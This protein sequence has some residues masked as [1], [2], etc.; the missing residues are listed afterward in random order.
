MRASRRRAFAAGVL[1]LT[2]LPYSFFMLATGRTRALEATHRDFDAA[3][4]WL[5]G[6]RARPGVVLSRHPGEVYLRTGR[7][8]L[9]VST[10][11]RP[12]LENADP[13]SVAQTINDYGVAYLLIDKERYAGAPASPLEKYVARHPDRVRLVWGRVS[14]PVV[15]YEVK[16]EGFPSPPRGEGARRAGEGGAA[17][18]EAPARG[19]SPKGG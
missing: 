17:Q 3:C 16:P 6:P 7:P 19:R 8:G 1:L 10:A 9:E 14:D 18:P 2:S 12:G 4:E 13:E 5:A 15:V 11:E